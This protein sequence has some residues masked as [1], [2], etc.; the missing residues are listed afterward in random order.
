MRLRQYRIDRAG[1]YKPAHPNRRGS[2]K[3]NTKVNKYLDKKLDVLIVA[4]A[5]FIE[6]L[7]AYAIK[8]KNLC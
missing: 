3:Q 2:H 4:H 5:P 7:Y 1:S 6:G 8:F